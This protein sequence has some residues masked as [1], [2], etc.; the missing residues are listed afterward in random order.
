[1]RSTVHIDPDQIQRLLHGE[2]GAAEAAVRAHVKSCAE[3]KAQVAR[4]EREEAELFGLLEQLDHAPP[5]VDAATIRATSRRSSTPWLKRAAIIVLSAGLAAGAYAL[6][7]SPLP[8]ALDRLADWLSRTGSTEQP[9]APEA[10][11]R[12][13]GISVDPG[14]SMAILFMN[15]QSSG[16]ARVTITDRGSIT[17]RALGGPVSFSSDVDRLIVE[18]QESTADY[19]IEIPRAAPRVEIGINGRAVFLKEGAR[20]V[21]DAQRNENGDYRIVF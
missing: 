19:E 12:T 1:M 15:A 11:P 2:L 16:E 20:I 6:P 3:C 17:V 13:S 9:P 7:G 21:T 18:N 5:V 8:R 14:A 4:A 10:V